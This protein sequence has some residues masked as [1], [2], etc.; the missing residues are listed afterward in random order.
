MKTGTSFG[1]RDS[2]AIGI[3]PDYVV[4]VWVGNADGEG[5][6]E[7][8]GVTSAGPILFDVFNALPSTTWFKKPIY[9]LEDFDLYLKWTSSWN[10]LQ[11][12]KTRMGTQKRSQYHDLSLPQIGSLRQHR[13]FQV[14]TR[15]TEYSS[16]ITESRFVLPPDQALYYQSTSIV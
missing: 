8:T 11:K 2:W 12:N 14:D 6:P 9:E 10:I 13:M 3:T 15:C 5:R 16:M 7:L 1:N 4:G